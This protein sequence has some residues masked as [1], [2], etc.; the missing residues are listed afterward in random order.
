MRL[1]TGLSWC[2]SRT[3]AGLTRRAGSLASRD[4]ISVRL[5]GAQRVRQEDWERTGAHTAGGG[6]ELS[7]RIVV[8]SS[9]TAA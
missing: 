3:S 2:R 1:P 4:L 9:L 7:A 5:P 6:A 8:Q